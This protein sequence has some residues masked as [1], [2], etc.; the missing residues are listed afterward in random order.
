MRVVAPSNVKPGSHETVTV[1]PVAV[2]IPEEV[3]LPSEGGVRIGQSGLRKKKQTEDYTT[4]L[5][6]SGCGKLSITRCQDSLIQ[7]TQ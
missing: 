5:F 6:N 2:V 1:V 4:N 3:K 7:T